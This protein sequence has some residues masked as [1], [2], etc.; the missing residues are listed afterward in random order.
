[1]T[2]PLFTTVIVLVGGTVMVIVRVDEHEP[3]VPVTLYVVVTAGEAVT[4]AP[5]VALNP[6]AGDQA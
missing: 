6:V 2:V 1:M 3:L 5:V 4:T